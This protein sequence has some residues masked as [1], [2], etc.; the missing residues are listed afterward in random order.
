MSSWTVYHGSCVRA[1]V[2][3][4]AKIDDRCI[5]L[6]FDIVQQI[7]C[8]VIDTIKSWS[9]TVC[10]YVWSPYTRTHIFQH[11]RAVCVKL[12]HC[13]IFWNHNNTR[14][15]FGAIETRKL[16]LTR[17]WGISHLNLI[18]FS[19]LLNVSACKIIVIASVEDFDWE[20]DFDK[21]IV[22]WKIPPTQYQFLFWPEQIVTSLTLLRFSKSTWSD[23]FDF[24]ISGSFHGANGKMK[25]IATVPTG[26][27]SDSCNFARACPEFFAESSNRCMRRQDKFFVENG[28][29][30]HLFQH[31]GTVINTVSHLWRA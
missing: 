23:Y 25:K 15:V 9:V 16:K 12:S 24:K 27:S 20:R 28:N 13:R 7:W 19:Q 4:R 22:W 30:G 26:F 1:V 21:S 14:S 11:I 3:L 10:D 17:K 29:L 31:T 18:H 5:A 8:M 6:N 2:S